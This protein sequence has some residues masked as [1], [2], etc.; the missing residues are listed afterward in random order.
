MTCANVT[1][2]AQAMAT[3][4]QYG[5]QHSQGI[6]SVVSKLQFFGYTI[7]IQLLK[8]PKVRNGRS[9][10]L[11]SQDLFLSICRKDS[12]LA[13]TFAKLQRQAKRGLKPGTRV[14]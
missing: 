5:S 12:E 4:E 1:I 2:W 8:L 14:Q 11:P 10:T 7:Y 9:D 3:G 13:K 6:L